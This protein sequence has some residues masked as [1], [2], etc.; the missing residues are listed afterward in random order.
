MMVRRLSAVDAQMHWMSAKIP[1]DQ[2]LLYGF[3]GVAS[4]PAQVL[5]QIRRRAQNC[6]DLRLRVEERNR[7]TYPAWVTGDIEP[8]QFVVHD[9]TDNSWAGCLAAVAGLAEHQLDAGRMTWRLHLFTPVDGLPG[10][11]VGTVTVLQATHALGDGIR[12]SALAAWLF[13]RAGEVPPVPAPPRFR[14]AALPWRSVMAAR[15]HRQLVRDTEAGLVPPQADSRPALHSNMRPDGTRS[16]RTVIRNRAQLPGPT[17]TVGV[18]AAVSTALASH[19]RELGDDPSTLGAEAPM[20]KASVRQAHNH[21]GN[22]GV[23]LHPEM[24]FG[25]RADR[26]AGDLA[27]RRRRAGHP[28]MLAS[29]RAFAAVPAPL[30]RWG[31]SQFDPTLRSPTVTG[32]TVVSSVN[33]GPADLRFGELPVVLTAGYPGLSP[34]MGL[35]HGVHGIGDTIAISVHAAESAI[36]DVDAYVERLESALGSAE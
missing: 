2:F 6:P 28:A 19:L 15:A 10:A 3:A 11:D 13:G 14:G 30:L 32:N 20:A 26:I 31:V 36:G 21:F 12:A 29:S 8:D 4:D 33:R 25:E 23:G 18:L 5:D 1:N 7:L 22:V 27:Q 34:M 35:T 24:D 9:L 17:V 16:I